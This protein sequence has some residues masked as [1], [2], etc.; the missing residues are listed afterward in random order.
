M[1][2]WRVLTVLALVFASCG[3]GGG[4]RGAAGDGAGDDAPAV[5]AAVSDPGSTPGGGSKAAIGAVD[6]LLT[7]PVVLPAGP[8]DPAPVAVSLRLEE[9]N[10]VRET[11]VADEGGSI[12]TTGADGTTYVLTIPD[13]AL[14]FDTEISMT[15]AVPAGGFDSPATS[16]AGVQL[17]PDGLRLYDWATL[18]VTP[19]EG[20]ARQP[21]LAYGYGGDGDDLHGQP[22]DPDPGR[23]AV[24]LL[25]FSGV[26]VSIGEGAFTSDGAP[27]VDPGEPVDFES[28]ILQEISKA[29]AE[30]RQKALLGDESE[31]ELDL[32]EVAN[33][34]DAYYETVVAPIL[35]RI[36]TSCAF[37]RANSHK[38]L[39]WLRQRALFGADTMMA[40]EAR[41]E[42][43]LGK[44]LA[45]CWDELKR[46]CID[47]KNPAVVRLVMGTARIMAL[48]GPSDEPD[49]DEVLEPEVIPACGAVHGMITWR[50]VRH[51]EPNPSWSE[52][53]DTEEVIVVDVNVDGNGDEFRDIGSTFSWTGYERSSSH[54]GSCDRTRQVSSWS[55]SG[56][57]TPNDFDDAR[58]LTLYFDQGDGDEKAYLSIS[59]DGVEKSHTVAQSEVAGPGGTKKCITEVSDDSQGGDEWAQRPFCPDR[60]DES[61]DGTFVQSGRRLDFSCTL[62]ESGPLNDGSYEETVTVSGTLVVS[63]S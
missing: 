10:R 61:L 5:T 58:S 4:G 23:I 19:A 62:T 2:R 16:V 1:S 14:V 54:Q 55:G 15:P 13:D 60:A 44:G 47:T 7:A 30:E 11:I 9:E 33:L 12:R 59:V 57:L 41:A 20:G 22:L 51:E 17:G 36:A 52:V 8:K 50:H 43:A 24:P 3:G 31:D 40:E 63:R 29:L 27:S 6:A 28:Q 46:R 32:E 56:A 35:D 42:V 21:A 34:R 48:L 45:N 26:L 37:S 49:P 53:V 25:H 18:T 39:G 38:V